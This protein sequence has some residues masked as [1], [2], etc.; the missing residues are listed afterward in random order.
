M[1]SVVLFGQLHRSSQ[2]TALTPPNFILISL[3]CVRQESLSCYAKRFP[4]FK[5]VFF[6]AKTPNIDR[7]ARDGI[8][9]EQHI[10]QAPFTPASHASIFT[11]LNPYNHG[12]RGMFSYKLSPNVATMA[13]K[14][15]GLGYQTGS[16]IGSHA[17]GSQYGLDRG[18][19]VFDESFSDEKRKATMP[20][21]GYRR[22]CCEVTD[23]AL[24]WLKKRDDRFFLFL[25]YFDAHSLP[26]TV[27]SA[28]SQAAHFLQKFKVMVR[29]IDSGVGSP[30]RRLLK[31]GENLWDSTGRGIKHQ[32][33]NVS[34]I[35][36]QIGRILDY[37]HHAG[38]YETTCIIVTSDHG[39]S[40]NEHGEAFHREYLYD[41][42]I[43]TPLIFKFGPGFAGQ[44]VRKLTRSIDIFPTIFELLDVGTQDIDGTG[45]LKFIKDHWHQD[46]TAYCE[47]RFEID[48]DNRNDLKTN[49]RGL[50]T[51]EWKFITN[52]LDD[53]FELYDLTKDPNERKDISDMFP[54]L[55]DKFETDLQNLFSSANI[56]GHEPITAKDREMVKERLRALGYL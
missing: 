24:E 47:T 15:K 7:L 53:S 52:L 3:D 22:D 8:L 6:K 45:L 27:D 34:S 39:D 1:G 29:N 43:K 33:K 13:E 55:V 2:M 20:G 12:I 11:G 14:F 49:Y 51:S 17:M 5:S 31:L 38:I 30:A 25:H 23:N 41:T 28:D 19:D 44:T 18:F 40:F 50:R 9:F 35:D 36:Y 48:P 21:M 32:L 26:R 37:L 46:L 56:P 42:T 10:C 16:F 54:S 4:W